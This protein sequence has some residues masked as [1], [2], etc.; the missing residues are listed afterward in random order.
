MADHDQYPRRFR[1]I[2]STGQ[3][4]DLYD[5]THKFVG[6]FGNLTVVEG[7]LSQPGDSGG[8]AF[9]N[10]TALGVIVATDSEKNLTVISPVAVSVSTDEAHGG[11]G[12][13]INSKSVDDAA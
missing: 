13:V 11:L 12:V 5:R 1:K 8:P 7:E 9:W 3:T 2:L 10:Y 4:M 6:R